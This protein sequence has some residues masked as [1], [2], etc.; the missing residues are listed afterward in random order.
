MRVWGSLVTLQHPVLDTC[1]GVRSG[2]AIC[3]G[4]LEEREESGRRLEEGA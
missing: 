2:W 1:K 4:D 3:A